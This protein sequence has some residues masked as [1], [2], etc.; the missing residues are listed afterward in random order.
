MA[1]AIGRVSGGWLAAAAI[2][3]WGAACGGGD[4]APPAS[5]ADAAPWIDPASEPPLIGSLAVDPADGALWMSTNRGLYRDVGKGGGG[6][7][8]RV[9]GTLS[10]PRGRGS[11]SAGLVVAFSGPREL[12]ASGHPDTDSDLPPVLGLVRSRDRARTWRSVSELGTA[13]FHVLEQSGSTLVGA[14]YGEGQILVSEDEG[15]TWRGRAAPGAGGD[16]AVE[17]SNPARWIVSTA[18]GLFATNDEGGTWRP[19]EPRPYARLAWPASDELV[20]MEAGGVVQRSADGGAS[21]EPVGEA[22]VHPEVLTAVSD[23]E[24]YA[25]FADGTVS[26][27]EDGGASWRDVLSPE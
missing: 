10:T 9:S 2:A 17:P 24:F 11:L 1:G 22:R 21:W 19:R 5:A 25:A 26:H 13:D 14:Q 18:D 12:L 16:Q 4:P 20:R 27:S 23:L 15:R 8:R 7:P 3:V 6:E